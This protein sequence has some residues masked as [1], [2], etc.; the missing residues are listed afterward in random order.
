MIDVPAKETGGVVRLG[1]IH[2]AV[3]Q[4]AGVVR[5]HVALR[6]DATQMRDAAAGGNGPA[7]LVDQPLRAFLSLARSQTELPSP[8]AQAWRGEQVHLL[9]AVGGAEGLVKQTARQFFADAFERPPAFLP[10]AA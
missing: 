2:E 6:A 9:V 5:D 7:E 8:S 10:A 4:F 3:D 1:A